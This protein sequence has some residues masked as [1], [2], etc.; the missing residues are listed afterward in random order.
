VPFQV[1]SGV[2]QGGILSPFLFNLNMNDLIEE[3]IKLNIGAQ[4]G[5]INTCFISYCDD[6][7]IL[8]PTQK[9]G[10]LILDVCS[11]FSRKWKLKFNPI[12][13]NVLTFGNP[14]LKNTKFFINNI[15]M[16][17]VKIKI[18]SKNFRT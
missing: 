14:V 17:E 10:Q 12:K 16:L 1:I 6:F 5:G 7:N 9:H 15:E 8:S 13:S 11:E 18:K 2:K 3:C 4:I